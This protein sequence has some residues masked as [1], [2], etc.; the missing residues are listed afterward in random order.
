MLIVP[1]PVKM[2]GTSYAYVVNLFFL[3]ASSVIPQCISVQLF[4]FILGI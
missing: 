1:Y 2:A 4:L 3:R